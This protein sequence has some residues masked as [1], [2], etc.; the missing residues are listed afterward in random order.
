MIV[1]TNSQKYLCYG[2]NRCIEH[3][4]NIIGAQ[5][6]Q[7]VD[8]AI[9]QMIEAPRAT[10]HDFVLDTDTNMIVWRWDKVSFTNALDICRKEHEA[11]K[12]VIP[13]RAKRK[14]LS[15]SQRIRVYSKTHGHCYLCGQFVDFDKF[16]VEH[17]IPLAIGG[18]ND[19]DNLFCS[20][21]ECNSMKGNIE[22]GELFKKMRQIQLHR[23]EN[24]CRHGKYSLKYIILNKI[25][26]MVENI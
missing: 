19:I 24:G 17:R 11:D 20:C 13:C 3:T 15:H 12:P 6:F 1:I 16:E 5:A 9:V 4:D 8:D 18:T 26:N 10:Q 23:I 14:A 22:H 7:S 25:F 21:H 2:K